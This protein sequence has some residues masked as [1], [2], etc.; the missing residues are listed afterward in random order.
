MD[1]CFT[2]LFFRA[3][4]AFCVLYNRTEH[5]QGFSIFELL[6]ARDWSKRITWP[7]MPPPGKLGNIVFPRISAHAQISALPRISAHQLGQTSNKRPPH[8]RIRVPLNQFQISRET[9]ETWFYC[10]FIDNLK[11][12]RDQQRIIVSLMYQLFLSLCACRVSLCVLPVLLNFCYIAALLANAVIFPGITRPF[13]GLRGPVISSII[14]L[15][16][17]VLRT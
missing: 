13:S 15:L 1:A 9:N 11:R 4:T 10:Q 3:L 2:L 14:E 12:Q 16:G 8:P 17:C 5:S 7:N 6:I